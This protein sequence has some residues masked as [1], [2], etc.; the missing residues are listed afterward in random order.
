MTSVLSVPRRSSPPST[1]A[2]RAALVRMP[3]GRVPRLSDRKRIDQH[4]DRHTILRQPVE[5][6]LQPQLHAFL[7]G[8]LDGGVAV[9]GEVV[10]CWS[11]R[12]PNRQRR[13]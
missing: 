1:P 13:P 10:R 2:L 8:V 12:V 7:G 9:V 11:R 4:T 6:Q 5:E 3:I